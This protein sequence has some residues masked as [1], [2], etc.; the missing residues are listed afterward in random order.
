[1]KKLKLSGFPSALH[2]VSFSLVTWVWRRFLII[3]TKYRHGNHLDQW[4]RTFWTNFLSPDLWLLQMKFGWNQF[5]SPG[6][7]WKFETV[8]SCVVQTKVIHYPWHWYISMYLVNIV[9]MKNMIHQSWIDFE[10]LTFP[11]FLP[12]HC[13][14]R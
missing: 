6:D 11:I 4:T 10:K 2:Q 13:I 3:F 7:V 14:G 12:Y 8:N 5:S 9:F 1:M